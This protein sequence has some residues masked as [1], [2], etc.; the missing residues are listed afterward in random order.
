M[1]RHP[2]S[3]D[4]AHQSEIG[5]ESQGFQGRGTLS[6]DVTEASFSRYQAAG[7]RAD[8]GTSRSLADTKA[9][10]GSPPDTRNIVMSYTQ[11]TDRETF[12]VGKERLRAA[13]K[14]TEPR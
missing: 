7:E 14:R 6:A 8:L 10:A 1:S 13:G 11:Q 4:I 5:V 3:L 12:P 9:R 2:E